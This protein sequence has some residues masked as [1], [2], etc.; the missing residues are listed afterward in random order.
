[1]K[2][3][4][5]D[6]LGTRSTV[7]DVLGAGTSRGSSGH[8]RLS[9]GSV[10]L[11]CVVRDADLTASA[12]AAAAAYAQKTAWPLNMSCHE[13]HRLV[14]VATCGCTYNAILKNLIVDPD[15]LIPDHAMA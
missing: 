1:M 15:D 4:T 11:R 5:V 12:A 13:N 10:T 6:V 2:L 7:C 9:Y 14:L 8:C 3:D